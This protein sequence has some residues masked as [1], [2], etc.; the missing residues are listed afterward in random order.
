MV[1]ETGVRISFRGAVVDAGGGRD[2]LR[3]TGVAVFVAVAAEADG[4]F[5]EGVERFTIGVGV[6]VLVAPASGEAGDLL[7]GAVFALFDG[8]AGFEVGCGAGGDVAGLDWDFDVA[9]EV[10]VEGFSL[11]FDVGIARI[12]I[13]KTLAAGIKPMSTKWCRSP[14]DAQD[15]RKEKEEFSLHDEASKE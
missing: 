13:R 1:L 4:V 15:R 9:L 5:G 3:V 2:S 10:D 8:V 7:R 12:H 6:A 11:G 14:H